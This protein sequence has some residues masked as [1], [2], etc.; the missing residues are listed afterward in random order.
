MCVY[1]KDRYTSERG[2]QI[3][4]SDQTEKEFLD[5]EEKK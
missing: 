5:R 4:I 3:L 1:Q 2:G